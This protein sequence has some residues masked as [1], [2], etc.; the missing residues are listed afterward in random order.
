[1]HITNVCICLNAM[2]LQCAI[3][4]ALVKKFS[5]CNLRSVLIFITTDH[6]LEKLL[7]VEEAIKFAIIFDQQMI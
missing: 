6:I 3:R 7:M 4:K 5:A 2:H 1:M